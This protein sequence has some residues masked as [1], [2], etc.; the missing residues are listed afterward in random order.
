M[1]CLEHQCTE[2]D[3]FSMSNRFVDYCPKCGG[4]VNSTFDELPERDYDYEDEEM[5][6]DDD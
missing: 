2:C 1:S 3:W 4:R 5:E 6:G